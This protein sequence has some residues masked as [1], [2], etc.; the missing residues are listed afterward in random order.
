MSLLV[1][2]KSELPGGIASVIASL[3]TALVI[4]LASLFFKPVRE[5]LF[6]PA[7]AN[8][9]PLICAA[10]PVVDEASQKLK[11]EFFIINRTGKE[12]VREDL[13]RILSSNTAQEGAASTPEIL[14]TYSRNVGTIGT[15]HVDENFNKDKGR[16][17]IFTPDKA[18]QIVVN[19]IKARAIMRVDIMIDNL[20]DLGAISRMTTAA[21]PFARDYLDACY[22][23]R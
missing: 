12:Y 1:K 9:Y 16:L 14:L 6:P 2:L 20:P 23:R 10:E 19:Q 3:T 21:V 5:W 18:I 4:F 7:V 11:V 8:D 22:T 17:S 15:V 13:A